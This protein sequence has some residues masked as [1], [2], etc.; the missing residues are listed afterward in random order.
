MPINDP[1][2]RERIA[3][4]S[5]AFDARRR[6]TVLAGQTD[7]GGATT[8]QQYIT[9]IYG[10]TFNVNTNV[11]VAERRVRELAKA[12]ANAEH[13]AK[14]Y[15]SD[16]HHCLEWDSDAVE[17]P[18]FSSMVGIGPLTKLRFNHEVIRAMGAEYVTNGNWV[19]RPANEALGD[20]HFSVFV[21]MRFSPNDKIAQARLA[22]LLN[23]QL[24]RHID[25]INSHMNDKS[26]IEEIILQGSAIMPIAPGDY[27]EVG[28]YLVDE[29]GPQSGLLDASTEYYGYVSAHRVSCTH[30][31]EALPTTGSSFDNAV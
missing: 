14:H 2:K 21:A 3:P 29:N 6:S 25:I 30:T 15:A 11:Q 7:T 27:V 28:V 8:I 18:W 22:L 23:G 1:I 16:W 17:Q 31:Y 12:I 4:G 24:W 10:P 5:L 13:R 19:F 26:H 9:N 20:W